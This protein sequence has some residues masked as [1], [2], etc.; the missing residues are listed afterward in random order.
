L[1]GN[2]PARDALAEVI[3]ETR[4]RIDRDGFCVVRLGRVVTEQPAAVAAGAATLL[5]SAFGTPFRVYAKNPNHWRSVGVDLEKAPY[6]SEGVGL[7]PLHMDFVNA[8]NPPDL[9]CLVCLRPD[10]CGGG[11]SLVAKTADIEELLD[12]R[13]IEVLSRP[14]YR[15]GQVANLSG[16]GGDIN[17]FAVL[18]PTP[19]DRFPCRY[20]GHLLNSVTDPEARAAIQAFGRALDARTVAIQLEAGDLLIVDQHRAVHGKLPLGAGQEAVPA[21]ARRELLL[22]FLRTAY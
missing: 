9:I 13:D 10:P 5:A 3:S 1:L 15:D 16:V 11:A 20:V 18:S 4:Q 8:E 17:P 7:L 2:M 12:P 22:S 6:R 19:G 14:V 21:P